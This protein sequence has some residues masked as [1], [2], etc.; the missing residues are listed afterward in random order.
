MNQLSSLFAKPRIVTICG[1]ELE[2]HKLAFEN[3]EHAII[4]G[5]WI[6][7]APLVTVQDAF[8]IC[9]PDC[10]ARE[11]LLQ[12]L[13]GCLRVP[14]HAERLTGDDVRQ[15]PIVMVAEATL[16]IVEDN[17]DFFM[18]SLP[19]IVARLGRLTLIGSKLPSSLSAPGMTV[20]G[21]VAT[22]SQS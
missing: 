19:A 21:S 11:P 3:F 22:A 4:V 14:G 9:K 10:P 1:V 15:M 8:S 16:A 2:L 7:S 5:E 13:A 12:V 20:L 18:E 17:I 6:G